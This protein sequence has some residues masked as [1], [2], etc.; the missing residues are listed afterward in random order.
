M[1]TQT[2]NYN[3]IKPAL[4][5]APPD[6]T[7]MNENWDKVDEE[8]TKAFPKTGGALSGQLTVIDNLNI[9]KTYDD[10]EYKSYIR[11][12]NYSIGNNGDFSTGLL[13]YKGTVSQA[14]LMFNKD[15]VM[16]RDN[17]NAKAYSLFGQHNADVTATSIRSNL[18][19]Y[20]TT[21]MTAGTSELATG[22]LYFVYE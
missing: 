4:T 10:V 18:Y 8:L 1:A 17:V 7:V 19:T 6:I 14:Q 13:H 9:N 22:K 15:G 5:D 3:F 16:L 21:D 2:T 20:G 11:P 12:I